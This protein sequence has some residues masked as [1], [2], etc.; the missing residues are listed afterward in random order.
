MGQM[1]GYFNLGK[2]FLYGFPVFIVIICLCSLLNVWQRFFRSAFMKKIFLNC[3]PIKKL[4]VHVDDPR[5]LLEEGSAILKHERETREE[6][7]TGVT[8]DSVGDI[9]DTRG[10]NSPHPKHPTINK[11]PSALERGPRD[12]IAP[13]RDVMPPSRVTRDPPAATGR[14]QF[15]FANKNNRYTQLRNSDDT[16]R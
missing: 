15:S 10:Q 3:W 14:P 9:S 16:V 4:K 13:G 2:S 5:Q 12:V 11:T 8:F 1:D 6:N 7:N